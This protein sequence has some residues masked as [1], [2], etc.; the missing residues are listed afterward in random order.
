MKKIN[1]KKINIYQIYTIIFIILCIGV[2]W[3]FIRNGKSFIWKPD[4]FK[5]HYIIFENFNYTMRNL[6]HEFS[7]FSWN[8]ALGLDKI[9]QF[10]YYILGDPFSYISLL[11]PMKY[12]KYAYTFLII[13]RIYCVGLSF[14]YYCKYSETNKFGTLIGALL[15]TFSGYVLFSSVR[16]P[17]FTNAAILLPL[18]FLGID[19]I[20]KEDKYNFFIFISAISAIS[21]YY[22]FYMITI[23]TF[24]YAIVKYITEYRKEGIK[25]F[26]I[27]FAKTT[28]SY[29]IGALI[30]SILLLPTIYTFAN[31]PRTGTNYTYY[32]FDYYIKLF[33]ME[34]STSYWTKIYVSPIIFLL[35]PI[36]LCNIKK[37]KTWLI[38]LLIQTIILLLPCLG[39][40]M[41]GFSFQSNRWIFA[42]TFILSYIVANNLRND[43]KYSKKE[44]TIATL[45]I[46]FYTIMWIIFKNYVGYF[47]LSSIAFSLV[48]LVILIIQNLDFAKITRNFK[49]KKLDFSRF[50]KNIKYNFKHTFYKCCIFLVVCCN[51]IFFAWQLFGLREYSH[52]FISFDKINSNYNNFSQKLPHFNEAIQYIQNNDSSFYRIGTNVYE[53]N[54]MSLKYNYNALNTYLSLGNKYVTNLSKDLLI[55]NNSKTNP[56]REFDSRTRI[57]TLL[58]CKYYVVSKKNSNYVPYGYKLIHEITDTKKEKNSAYIYENQYALPIGV[59][60]NN[61]TLKSNYE[62]LSPLEKEQALLKTA[63]IDDEKLV[64]NYNINSDKTILTNFSLKNVN[65]KIEDK[66]IKN[67]KIVVSNKSKSFKIQLDD[68]KTKNCELYLLFE[69]LKYD[70]T[71]E[72]SITVKYNKMNKKQMVRNKITSPYYEYTP[73]ILF[74]LGYSDNHSGNTIK[75]K[76][77]ANGSYSFD[78]IKLIAI[79]MD[80][81]ENDISNL[82]KTKFN[83]TTAKNN[84]LAGNINNSED[85]ILQIS[86]SYSS[87]WTAY[88]DGT[89]TNVISVNTGFIGIPLTEGEHYIELVYS[90]PYIYLGIS[91]SIIGVIAFIT[92]CCFR[93]S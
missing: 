71:E 3:N 58:G 51:I 40:L 14:I 66:I 1:V 33:F 25:T 63:V 28:L 75:V 84:L 21:N 27:K 30:A 74:N 11:F 55:L 90:T 80:S 62:N 44:I 4:G 5:Q 65:Y 86:A 93:K 64:D 17:F 23:L 16:H 22:F 39:S 54:N 83:I 2:F 77:S 78:N 50:F 91:I 70:S 72:Y 61:Y 19:K 57:T 9:G 85:G 29:I 49:F 47:P 53:S 92:I 73:N 6:V 32:D 87:G 48:F 38:N 37:N 8:T 34:N 10:S 45:A 36:S 89:K 20:L 41:N 76:F 68:D 81:Y 26:W 60:Y 52:E 13:L 79:P 88:I 56:L 31:A 69:N 12:L 67:N 24:I 7:T 35:V 15:Y 42:Y 43:L 46:C 82:S 18:M 59:F